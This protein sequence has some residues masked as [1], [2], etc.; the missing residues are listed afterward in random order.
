MH[1][2]DLPGDDDLAALLV[3]VL[4]S[5]ELT[6]EQPNNSPSSRCWPA[7]YVKDRTH[8]QKLATELL[9]IFSENMIERVK[10]YKPTA[11]Y[12]LEEYGIS[13]AHRQSDLRDGS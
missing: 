3:I 7:E 4:C 12:I 10:K 2:G 8:A 6:P 13:P 9:K 11:E 1:T 5:H